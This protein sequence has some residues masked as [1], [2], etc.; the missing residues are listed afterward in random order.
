MEIKGLLSTVIEKEASDL[1][2][3]VGKPPTL[4][5]DDKLQPIKGEEI[6][7]ADM[8]KKL[9]DQ[10]LTEKQKAKL[11]IE[12]EIDLSYSFN[13]KGRF[14]VNVYFQEGCL[15]VALRLI[16]AKIKTLKELGLPEN[17]AN[18]CQAKQGFLLVV[19]PAGHGKT[20]TCA[21]LVDI[22]NHSRFDHIITIEDPIEYVFTPDKCLIDQ[23]EVGD[24]TKSFPRAL[25]SCLRQ[26]P[27]VIFVGELRDYETIA[28]AM[29]LAETGH[30]VVSTLHTNTASQTVDRLID[31]F[32]SHQQQQIRSQ[33]ASALLGIISQRLV[34]R[35]K[36]GRA[37]AIEVL[38]IM[39][40]V[41]NLIREGKIYQLD[42]VIRTNQAEGMMPL[43]MSL[44]KLVDDSEISY[45]DAYAYS[46]DKKNFDKLIKNANK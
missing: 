20:T 18:F 24:D 28:T 8:V 37:A 25:R 19:G 46:I 29:T 22:I 33:L 15:A 44:A 35:K 27:D 4:R 6:L 34:P 11:E 3:T 21:A 10:L 12:R 16:P 14:R 7:T 5:I 43:D 39:P 42:N 36:G 23:R 41:Q 17:L 2:I 40:A 9:V 26:D 32:P 45:E 31:V 38:K 30:L 13:N 1:H